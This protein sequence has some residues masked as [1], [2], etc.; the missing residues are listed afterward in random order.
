MSVYPDWNWKLFVAT[1]FGSG[2]APL[3]PGTFGTLLGMLPI[4]VIASTN[5]VWWSYLILSIVLTWLGLIVTPYAQ[6]SYR[7]ADPQAV[8]IDEIA[9]LPLVFLFVPTSFLAILLGFV[10]FRTFD[11]LKPFPIR[12][13]EQLPGAAGLMFD[14]TLAALYAGG[15]LWGVMLWVN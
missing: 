7:T 2:L 15:V 8:V 3:A 10:L 11:I 1:G 13:L 12:R 14:D 6:I 5:P 9:A 4:V